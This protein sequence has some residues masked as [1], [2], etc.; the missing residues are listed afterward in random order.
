MTS[1]QRITVIS[2]QLMLFHSRIHIAMKNKNL[3]K[4]SEGVE[5]N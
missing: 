2:V 5:I 1:A 3:R 4:Y